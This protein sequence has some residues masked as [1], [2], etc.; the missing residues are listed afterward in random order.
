MSSPFPGMDP[1]LERHWL[2]VHTILAAEIRRAL[3]K[4]LPRGLVARVEERMAVESEEVEAVIRPDVRVFE[5]EAPEGATGGGSVVL[6]A[7]YKLVVELDPIVE[8]FIRVLDESGSVITVI[9]IISPT[10]K[11]QPGLHAFREKRSELVRSGVH[12]VEVDLVRAGDWRALMRPE[13]CP[14]EAVTMYRAT[15]RTA[16]SRRGGYL[17]PF[18]LRDVLPSIPIPLRL[19]DT[20]VMLPL[21]PLIDAVCEDGRYAETIDYRQPPDPPLDAQDE[22][23]ADALLR[24]AGNR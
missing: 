19:T 6:D 8:R 13:R 14:A 10:N 20:P 18:G 23:W 11:R 3:N 4:V 7:P 1:Y 5:S 24:A 2:D 9:E 22:A 21:R 16:G 15:A 17:F 12:V